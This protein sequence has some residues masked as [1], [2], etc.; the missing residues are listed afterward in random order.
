MNSS[1]LSLLY[2]PILYGPTSVH[3]YWKNYSYDYMGLCQQSDALLF[4]TLSRFVIAFL[5]RSKCL[6]ISWLQSPVKN[7]P[8]MQEIRAQSLDWEDPLEKE[9]VSHSSILAWRILWIEEP[10]GLQSIGSQKS[11]I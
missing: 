11:K 2:G 1:V 8:E 5:P 10:C 6:L 3:D 4:N 7:L 9:M